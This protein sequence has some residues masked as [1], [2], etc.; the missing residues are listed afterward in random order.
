MPHLNI[1]SIYTLCNQPFRV[2]H[3]NSDALP[4]PTMFAGFP[5][6]SD[7]RNINTCVLSTLNHHLFRPLYTHFKR[8]HVLGLFR[9]MTCCVTAPAASPS[10]GTRGGE[11]PLKG[12]VTAGGMG[13]REAEEGEGREFRED[14]QVASDVQSNSKVRRQ[15]SSDFRSASRVSPRAANL[16]RHWS[17]PSAPWLLPSGFVSPL[18]APRLLIPASPPPP[19]ANLLLFF[20]RLFAHSR[21][22]KINRLNFYQHEPIPSSAPIS[23][24][25]QRVGKN[26]RSFSRG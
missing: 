8:H 20:C 12:H 10:G 21:R 24:F 14:I 18:S 23:V 16:L 4:L 1:K 22:R 26:R 7:L 6:T 19:V 2:T 25:T 11:V 15:L 17:L 13:K 9:G 3:N 5:F